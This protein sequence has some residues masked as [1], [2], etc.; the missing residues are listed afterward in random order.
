MTA[1]NSCAADGDTTAC[2]TGLT[3][4]LSDHGAN[5]ATGTYGT[6]NTSGVIE[7]CPQVHVV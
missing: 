5:E 6:Y 4:V 3:A 7:I 2:L 1:V